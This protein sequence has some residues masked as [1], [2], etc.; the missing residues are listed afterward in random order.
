MWPCDSKSLNVI[1]KWSYR[2]NTS[3]ILIVYRRVFKSAHKW[4]HILHKLGWKSSRMM[5]F[6]NTTV[7]KVNQNPSKVYRSDIEGRPNH[8]WVYLSSWTWS[9][10]YL[11]PLLR[12]NT[13]SLGTLLM[14]IG[15]FRFSKLSMNSEHPIYQINQDLTGVTLP[16]NKSLVKAPNR[17][18]VEARF[19]MHLQGSPGC[20][21]VQVIPCP[22]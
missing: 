21:W 12:K 15:Y 7:C 6:S 3:D 14:F 10:K 20:Y 4:F 1:Y 2:P 17:M 22:G 11:K 13:Y 18:T 8:V 9:N 16:G 19:E 5:K